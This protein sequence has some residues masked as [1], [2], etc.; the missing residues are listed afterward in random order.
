MPRYRVDVKAFIS[1]EVTAPNVDAARSEAD[2]LV[3]SCDPTPGFIKGWNDSIK[4][5][6]PGVRIADTDGFSVDGTSE[7]ERVC[8]ECGEITDDITQSR[9]WACDEDEREVPDDTPSLDTSFHDHEM[10]V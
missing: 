6:R 2:S 3:Y 4:L 8:D 10:N 7:V 5:D 9:C 1:I